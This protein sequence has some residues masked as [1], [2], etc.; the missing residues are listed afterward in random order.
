MPIQAN[1][2]IVYAMD[3]SAGSR[4]KMYLYDEITKEGD[5]DWEEWKEEES[6]TSAK[7]FAEILDETPAGQPIDL[8]INSAGGDVYEANAIYANLARHGSI[9]AYIDGIAYSAAALVAMAADHIVMAKGSTM[10][11]HNAWT[12]CMGN[13]DQL[14]QEADNLDALMASNRGV[15]MTRFKGTEQEL[16]SL[17]EKEQ[18]LST[19]DCMKYGFAD[20]VCESCGGGSDDNKDKLDTAGVAIEERITQLINAAKELKVRAEAAHPAQKKPEHTPEQKP[21]NLTSVL[22]DGLKR[23]GEA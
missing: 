1:R 14:R 21:I 12:I 16:I 20:E 8:Y 5:F 3:S 6:E 23:V 9:T 18:V 13:A 11:V 7:H 2:K 4:T 10:L 15:F 19:D 17:M 22:L